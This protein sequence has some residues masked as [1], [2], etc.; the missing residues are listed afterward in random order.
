MDRSSFSYRF[1]GYP[2]YGLLPLGTVETNGIMYV[3]LGFV[4]CL[5][6]T[7]SFIACPLASLPSGYFLTFGLPMALLAS[8]FQRVI[9]IDEV[10][11]YHL[12]GFVILYISVFSTWA[13][14]RTFGAT[15]VWAWGSP[16]ILLSSDPVR[17]GWLRLLDVGFCLLRYDCRDNHM[18]LERRSHTAQQCASYD[19]DDDPALFLEPYSF[20]M[21]MIFGAI[22]EVVYLLIDGDTIGLGHLRVQQSCRSLSRW[23]PT[24]STYP[25]GQ[26]IIRCRLTSF[27]DKGSIGRVFR[28]SNRLILARLSLGFPQSRC[29][30]IF[31]GWRS[32][33]DVYIGI[34]LSAGALLFLFRSNFRESP[35]LMSIVLIACCGQLFSLGLSLKINSERSDVSHKH[36][37][38][39]DYLM[40]A[41]KAVMTLPH[42]LVSDFPP[43]KYMRAVS[44]WYLLFALAVVVMTAVGLS[45]FSKRGRVGAAVASVLALWIAAE[46]APNYAVK[47]SAGNVANRSF[48]RFNGEVVAELRK[49][50]EPSEKV[51]FLGEKGPKNEYL[52]LYLCAA[53]GC[54][55]FNAVGDKSRV[56]A[57]RQWPCTLQQAQSPKHFKRNARGSTR[58]TSAS[59][60]INAVVLANFDLRW[61]SYPLGPKC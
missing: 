41:D 39:H 7:S 18:A 56:I 35:R 52:S 31:H 34:G 32:R 16:L 46:Y 19:C 21:A 33:A 22:Y 54:R 11:A 57:F 48:R 38:F 15:R 2:L 14:M 36:I 43:I 1:C 55:T 42:A 28:P 4:D 60:R 23:Q 27:V 58:C 59:E 12:A 6:K 53:V 20:V 49:L 29:A 61:D 47:T 5:T 13:L 17:Q 30:P 24:S 40:P 8:E 26:T 37:A 9:G 25:E 44:R 50:V 3:A 45:R 51:F 10:A